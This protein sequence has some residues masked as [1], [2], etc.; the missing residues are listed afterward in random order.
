[1]M[2]VF[3]VALVV[4]AVSG[5]ERFPKPAPE[6]AFAGIKIVDA[7]GSP[8]RRP[9][10]DW[11][12]ART[13]VA[14]AAWR[15]WLAARR[16]EIDDWMAKR[17]DRVEWV[18]GWWH[19]FVNEKDGAFLEWTPEPPLDAKP[20]VFGGWVF[21]FRSRHGDKILEAAR[22]WRLT[23]ERPTKRPF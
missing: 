21:G 2:R 7:D 15:P 3:A 1:M 23:G 22:L 14:E 17:Q 19:D 11:Q 20:K 13:R 10:E 4:C 5:Q 6:R 8:L 18:A 9:R 12:G 16:A